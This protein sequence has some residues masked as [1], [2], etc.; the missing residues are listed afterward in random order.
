MLRRL[1]VLVIPLALVVAACSDDD[2][3]PAGGSST[4]TEKPGGST[5]TTSSSPTT[6]GRGGTTSSST[7]SGPT[8]QL[9]GS[10]GA[11]SFTWSVDQTRSEFCYHIELDSRSAAEQ[12]RLYRGSAGQSGDVVLNLMPPEGDGTVTSCSAGDQLLVEE[13]RAQPSQFFV[14]VTTSKGTTRGQLA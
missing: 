13:I 1:I 4:T 9:S 11:G 7:P 5:T 3:E 10:G 12:A 2:D 8:R 6:G 14:E